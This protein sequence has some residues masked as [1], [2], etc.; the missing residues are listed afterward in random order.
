[1]QA[2]CV[3]ALCVCVC[4]CVYVCVCVCVCCVVV[5]ARVARVRACANPLKY[6]QYRSNDFFGMSDVTLTDFHSFCSIMSTF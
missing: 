3:C 1:M 2:C 5:N 4:V 6:V